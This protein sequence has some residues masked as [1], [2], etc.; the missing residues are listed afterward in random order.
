MFG[1][2]SHDHIHN[3]VMRFSYSS[4]DCAW[5]SPSFKLPFVMYKKSNKNFKGV[6]Q[7]LAKNF[8]KSCTISKPGSLG[9]GCNLFIKPYLVFQSQKILIK[10]LWRE[11]KYWPLYTGE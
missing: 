11:E 3:Y 1:G 8:P 5:L 6:Y 7:C 9:E 2:G 4:F 10:A